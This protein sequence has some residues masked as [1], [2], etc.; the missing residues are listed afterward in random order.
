M[1]TK[2]IIISSLGLALAL[3]SCASNHARSNGS[4]QST[5][6]P[7]TSI[8]PAPASIVGKTL[9]IDARKATYKLKLA[10]PSEDY[11]DWRQNAINYVRKTNSYDYSFRAGGKLKGKVNWSY[12]YK[13][14]HGDGGIVVSPGEGSETILLIF[15]TPTTG[16]AHVR[17]DGAIGS[18]YNNSIYMFNMP[19]T[20]K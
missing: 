16:T 4:A 6:A 3:S 13:P 5:V 15:Q 11:A 12:V 20:L 19:F 1:K 17:V 10:V 18:E 14:I 8:C 9:H 7:S 2:T